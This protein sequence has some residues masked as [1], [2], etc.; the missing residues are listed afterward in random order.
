MLLLVLMIS[1]GKFEFEEVGLGLKPIKIKLI[2]THQPT[3][4]SFI[5]LQIPGGIMHGVNIITQYIMQIAYYC[6]STLL[7]D[8][9]R[10]EAYL[11]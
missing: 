2:I 5:K 10:S 4:Q 6:Y 8:Y 7:Y 3:V 9:N 11:W 1:V